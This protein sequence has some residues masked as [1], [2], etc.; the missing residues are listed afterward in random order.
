MPRIPVLAWLLIFL[1]RI[2]L[3]NESLIS[4]LSLRLHVFWAN[5]LWEVGVSKEVKLFISYSRLYDFSICKILKYHSLYAHTRQGL[6]SLAFLYLSLL[7]SCI[8]HNFSK[9]LY[10]LKIVIPLKKVQIYF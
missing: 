7:K 9:K 6:I 4:I 5:Y 8:N 2:C 3:N 10:K 1:V